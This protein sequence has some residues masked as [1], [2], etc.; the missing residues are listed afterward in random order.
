M[1]C[2][3]SAHPPNPNNGSPTKT[4]KPLD[5]DTLVSVFDSAESP[6]A[7]FVDPPSVPVAEKARLPSSTKL[8]ELTADG[9]STSRTALYS[10]GRGDYGQLVSDGGQH[11]VKTP[12]ICSLTSRKTVI[13]AAGSLYHT[14]LVMES[15]ELYM[16][17]S[18]GEGQVR[19]GSKKPS[20]GRP[21]L[22][23]GVNEH[24]RSV[25]AGPH[26]TVCVTHTGHVLT[27]GGNEFGQVL[28]PVT[29]ASLLQI[30]RNATFALLNLLLVVA[31]S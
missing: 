25:A 20:F 24:V 15:G 2:C 9:V 1:G 17:G 12:V 21:V 3:H 5:P 27:F 31:W 23:E 11:T 16:C 10:W 19:P 6:E 28:R 7:I 30:S 4:E 22:M 8:I 29:F 13:Y 14:A 18:N 26:H